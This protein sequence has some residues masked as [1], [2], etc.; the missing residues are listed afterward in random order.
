MHACACF[1]TSIFVYVYMG[2]IF[3]CIYIFRH[4]VYKRACMSIHILFWLYCISCIY[5]KREKE[6][7]VER[8]QL[9]KCFCVKVFSDLRV[10]IL[11]LILSYF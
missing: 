2:F 4:F 1:I 8:L 5:R 6:K 3:E 7:R 11:K 10:L 9:L